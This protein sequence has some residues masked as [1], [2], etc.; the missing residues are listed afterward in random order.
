MEDLDFLLE[1]NDLDPEVDGEEFR[2][3]EE[4]GLDFPFHIVKVE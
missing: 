2:R 4:I 1:D 3:L